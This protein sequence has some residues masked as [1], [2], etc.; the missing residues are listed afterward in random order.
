M[1]S[2]LA[3]VPVDMSSKKVRFEP[4]GVATFLLSYVQ[5]ACKKERV[6]LAMVQ[7]GFVRA[8]RDYAGGSDFLMGDLFG[9]FAFEGQQAIIPIK[10]EII[11]ASCR[12]TREAPKPA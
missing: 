6:E 5:R 11:Q 8:K 1:S 7:G 12:N 10:G 4:S 3:K 9:E 2:P